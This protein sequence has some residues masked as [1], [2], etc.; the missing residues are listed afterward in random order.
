MQ[1]SALYGRLPTKQSVHAIGPRTGVWADPKTLPAAA[2]EFEAD[3][4][5]FLDN[6]EKILP[7]YEFGDYD[8]LVLPPSFP[9]GGMVSTL[10]LH[11]WQLV[12]RSLADRLSCGSR[13]CTVSRKTQSASQWPV[14]YIPQFHAE[15]SF[16]VPL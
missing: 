3:M 7:K 12:Q 1:L 11:T 15:L 14:A 4:E 13:T 10:P 9:F 8:V 16:C 2:W 6:A 5:R